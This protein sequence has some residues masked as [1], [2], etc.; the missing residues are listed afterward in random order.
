MAALRC[1]LT[2]GGEG[3]L[4]T[5]RDIVRF[6]GRAPG[7]KRTGVG[8]GSASPESRASFPCIRPSLSALSAFPCPS[9][10]A[11]YCAFAMALLEEM[12]SR[13]TEKPPPTRALGY[14]HVTPEVLEGMILHG[15]V[16][17]S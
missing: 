10:S 16:D 7:Y 3:S 14:S 15:L 4:V 12:A 5:S 6:P 1:Y 13:S 2:V 17:R 11:L 9:P 8:G